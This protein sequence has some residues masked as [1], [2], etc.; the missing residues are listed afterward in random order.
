MKVNLTKEDLELIGKALIGHR[1]K[2]EDT[3]GQNDEY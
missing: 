2:V 3:E 1:W